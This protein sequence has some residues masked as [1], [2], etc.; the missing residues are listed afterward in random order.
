MI[1]GIEVNW[2]RVSFLLIAAPHANSSSKDFMRAND[3]IFGAASGKKVRH[4]KDD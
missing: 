2:K 4:R 1:T 3:P